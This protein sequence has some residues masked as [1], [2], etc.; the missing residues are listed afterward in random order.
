MNC[1][2]KINPAS[3]FQSSHTRF[4]PHQ[5][6]GHGP[7]EESTTHHVTVGATKER[8]R[9]Y[10]CGNV[11]EACAKAIAKRY[12]GAEVSEGVFILDADSR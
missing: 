6:N 9:G 8:P 1:L 5:R 11:D 3:G 10:W 7:C 2:L 12:P 4:C